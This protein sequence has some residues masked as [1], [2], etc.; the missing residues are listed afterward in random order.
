MENARLCPLWLLF[1]EAATQRHTGDELH[2]AL[3]ARNYSRLLE[4]TVKT[5]EDW[6]LIAYDQIIT[7]ARTASR[8]MPI[9]S[10]RRRRYAVVDD[11]LMTR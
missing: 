10:R 4:M 1:R 7:L 9:P 2:N 8:Q 3:A 5:V 11:F 6:G